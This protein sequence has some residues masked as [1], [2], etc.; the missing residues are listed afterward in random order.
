MLPVQKNPMST[1]CDPTIQNIDC[2]SCGL[3]GPCIPTT[4]EVPKSRTAQF[5]IQIL[6]WCGLW[7][8]TV[9]LLFGSAEGSGK[10]AQSKSRSYGRLPEFACILKQRAPKPWQTVRFSLDRQQMQRLAESSSLL[11][12]SKFLHPRCPFLKHPGPGSRPEV[13]MGVLRTRSAGALLCRPERPH[14]IGLSKPLQQESLLRPYGWHP[15][16]CHCR[17]EPMQG[18]WRALSSPYACPLEPCTWDG[19]K[20][21][22]PQTSKKPSFSSAVD[23]KAM[24]RIFDF[25]K[26]S[27]LIAVSLEV[28]QSPIWRM[29][30]TS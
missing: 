2:C 10:R 20:P 29:A 27:W 7:N 18:V 23:L 8:P 24:E 15:Q 28:A 3:W 13:E 11:R 14:G 5:W 12:R 26:K 9:D 22:D 21:Q 19:H 6:L 25:R 1:K 30:K 4:P 17:S 16:L